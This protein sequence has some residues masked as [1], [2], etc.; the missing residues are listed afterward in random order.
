ML[1]LVWRDWARTC[2]RRFWELLL[3]EF[4]YL[5]NVD[6][7]WLDVMNSGA[8]QCYDLVGFRGRGIL[9]IEPLVLQNNHRPLNKWS[10]M[11]VVFQFPFQ[12]IFSQAPYQWKCFQTYC[13]F[14]SLEVQCDTVFKSWE[15]WDK[16]ELYGAKVIQICKCYMYYEPPPSPT[17]YF[18]VCMWKWVQERS[19]FPLIPNVFLRM[20]YCAFVY[21]GE[22][23]YNSDWSR[24]LFMLCKSCGSYFQRMDLFWSNS[25]GFT[26]YLKDIGSFS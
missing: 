7:Y 5:L 15:L 25:C 19:L 16:L 22:L 18:F 8:L 11:N 3:T 4:T 23:K 17:P 1:I 14:F 9:F 26:V 12:C 20:L 13:F 21:L 6:C 2:A 24:S 10:F